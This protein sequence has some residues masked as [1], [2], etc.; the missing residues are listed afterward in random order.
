M[1]S[2]SLPGRRFVCLA[3]HWLTFYHRTL[4]CIKPTL[5]ATTNSEH[6]SFLTKGL[7]SKHWNS[8]RSFTAVINLLTFYLM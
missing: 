2:L 5:V 6:V 8:L 3:F 4:F 7:C 1:N